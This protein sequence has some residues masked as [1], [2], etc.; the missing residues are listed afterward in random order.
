MAGFALKRIFELLSMSILL[1]VAGAIAR[2]DWGQSQAQQ[3]N[4]IQI[5][6]KNNIRETRDRARFFAQNLPNA[7]AFQT[8]SGWY[9][10][11]VGP[12]GAAEAVAELA[13]LKSQ[14][15]VPGDSFISDGA[16]FRGQ[17][18]P[19]STNSG[20]TTTAEAPATEATTTTAPDTTTTVEPT[21]IAASEPAQTDT[22]TPAA[23]TGPIPDEDLTATKRLERTWNSEQKKLYQT[24][25]VWTGDYNAAIDGSYGRGTRAAIKGFQTREG[26]Q[27]TG[28]LTEGQANLLK[29]RYDTTIARIGLEPL[30]DLDA[31]VEISYPANLVEFGRFEPPFVHYKPKADSRVKMMLISQTGGRDMLTGLYDIMSTFDYIPPDGYRK[32]KRNWFVLSGRNDTVVS[33]TYARTK[34]GIIKGFTLIWPPKLDTEM[35]PLATAMYNSFTPLDAYV[36]DETLGYGQS[37]DQPVDLTSGLDTA[38]PDFAATGFIINAEGVVLTDANTVKACKRVT[39]GDGRELSVVDGPTKLGLAV[40]RPKKPF[41]PKS[42]ALFSDEAVDLGAAISIAGF[43]FPDVM[44]RATLNYGTITDTNGLSGDNKALRVSAFLE[45]GDAGGP[46]LDDR[47]AVIGMDL[48]KPSADMGLPEYVNFALKSGEIVAL[49]DQYQLTYGTSRAFD[50]VVPED[51]AYMASNFTVKVSCWK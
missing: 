44:E 41:S 4:W 51:L 28:Y 10:I 6:S 50:P 33:Y 19:L 1:V 22:S 26:Y 37:A 14:N 5:E 2:P 48:K 20:A 18:W 3:T 36:L 25:M 46:V 23:Q 43:S 21:T 17:L 16:S 47:G 45:H 34:G 39:I 40:L 15:R 35:Q 9:A 38:A 12:Y 24:Y 27:D 11:V 8:A 42:Y 29:T 13:R 32:K 31:G 7:K 49:L 30:R